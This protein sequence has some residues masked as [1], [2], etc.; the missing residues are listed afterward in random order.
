MKE[1]KKIKVVKYIFLVL[2][3]T[4]SA[5]FMMV[6][7]GYYEY[8]NYTKKVFTEEQIKKFE[9]DI[10]NG[11]NLDINDYLVDEKKVTN[12]KQIG[13]KISE[14]IGDISRKSIEKIF[15]LLNKVIES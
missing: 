9:E 3:M 11:I 12:K 2:F 7:L 10:K 13:L 5:I 1:D 15:N 4:Y 14:I 8:S 6:K